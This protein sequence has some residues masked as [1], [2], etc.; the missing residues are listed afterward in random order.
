[1]LDIWAQAYLLPRYSFKMLTLYGTMHVGNGE[2]KQMRRRGLKL[3]PWCG[4][5]ASLIQDKLWQEH[6]YN[7]QTITHGYVGNYE[8]YVCCDNNECWA[9]APNGKIDDIYRSPEEAI[10]LAKEAWQRRA[11]DKE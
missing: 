9:V 4:S 11:Y 3:C 7:G 10:R 1:M 8:Y 5:H 2:K 6:S